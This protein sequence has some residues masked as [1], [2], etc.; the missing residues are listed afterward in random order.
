MVAVSRDAR[1]RFNEGATAGVQN[2]D[3][4]KTA[5]AHAMVLQTQRSQA[6]AANKV[7]EDAQSFLAFL[8]G[9]PPPTVE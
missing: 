8:L 3:M 2:M 6:F 1:A 4:R 7:V 9:E 5:L